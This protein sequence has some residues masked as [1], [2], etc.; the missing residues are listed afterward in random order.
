[1]ITTEKRQ[2][3]FGDLLV[4][5]RVEA[6]DERG[7]SVLEMLAP[8]GDS[9]PLHV[10]RDADEVFHVLEGRVRLHVDGDELVAGPGET[11]VAPRAV[12]HSYLVESESARWLV[13]TA[14]DGFERFVQAASRPA[15]ADELPPHAP[16]TPEGAAA[17]GALAAEHGIDLVGAPLC[18]LV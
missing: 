11:V 3:W 14:G 16:M 5:P 15:E 8:C 18:A 9:P 2:L 6:G 12:P 7:L 10:H 1:V 17:L 13:I 4:T